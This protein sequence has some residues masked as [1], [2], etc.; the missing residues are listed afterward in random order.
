MDVL[1]KNVLWC[2]IQSFQNI[3][4]PIRLH[5]N[6]QDSKGRNG[7]KCAQ[8][9]SYALWFIGKAYEVEVC[10]FNKCM[11]VGLGFSQKNLSLLLFP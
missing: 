11:F 7:Q 9:I 4:V 8:K 6:L 1:N 10:W 3:K 5:C 2:S